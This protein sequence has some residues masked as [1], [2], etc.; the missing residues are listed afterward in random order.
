MDLSG[1]YAEKNADVMKVGDDHGL[2]LLDEAKVFVVK[3]EPG[4][5]VLYFSALLRVIV[6]CMTASI[7]NDA[8]LAVLDT[9]REYVSRI[10][11]ETTP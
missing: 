3:Q 9:A 2:A 7:G 6:H 10:K 4:R 1:D 11:G 8:A 5:R